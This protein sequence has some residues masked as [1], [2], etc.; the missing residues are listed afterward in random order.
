MAELIKAELRLWVYDGDINNSP[1]KPNYILTKTKLSGDDVITF[2]ISELI[3]DYVDVEFDGNYEGVKLTKWVKWRI[4]R[5]FKDENDVETTD[6]FSERAI[7][8]RGY[9]D[10]TDGIN[11]ELSKDLLISNTV[12]NNYCGKK[13]TIPF[14][15]REDGVTKVSY[16][17]DQTDLDSRSLGSS[18]LYTI[19]QEVRLNPPNDDVVT[20]DKTASVTTSSDSSTAVNEIP[21]GTEEV[22]YTDSN[23]VERTVKIEC[24]DEC[25]NTPYKIS[26]VNKFGV[27]QDIWFFAKRKDTMTAERDQYK[28]SI[29]KTGSASAS[30]NISDHQRVYLENQGREVITMNTGFIHPSYNEV[31]KQLLVSEYVYIHHRFRPSPTNGR[32][33]LAVPINVVTSSLDIKTQR[34]DKLINYELQFEMDSEFIQSVR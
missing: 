16:V 10:I 23:G 27:M 24:I 8:F 5:T 31:M 21:I 3:K 30:Y 25:K 7:A 28:R 33:D 22:K 17:Q 26:F 34:D 14:Y 29:L 32:Y 1:E 2:E 9:G 11:P 20:I 18:D 6:A 12:V 19:A 13:V 15:T 4:E